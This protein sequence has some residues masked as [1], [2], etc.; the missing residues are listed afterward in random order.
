MISR[1]TTDECL[2]K[3][4]MLKFFPIKES[5]IAEIGRSM[6]ELCQSDGEARELVVSG[7]GAVHGMAGTGGNNS[8]VCGTKGP[9][10]RQEE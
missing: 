5:V 10:P 2:A 7:I 9:Q 6:I 4:G 1:K 8:G 3:L